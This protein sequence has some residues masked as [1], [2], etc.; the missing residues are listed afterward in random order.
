MTLRRLVLRILT[1]YI[2]AGFFANTALAQKKYVTT[3][4]AFKADER[5]RAHGQHAENLGG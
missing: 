1:L 4:V 3:V 5:S 2:C